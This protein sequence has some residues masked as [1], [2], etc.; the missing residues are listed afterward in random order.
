MSY[1]M[2]IVSIILFL[3]ITSIN[4]GWCQ[5][6]K[7]PANQFRIKI[8]YFSDGQLTV[9]RKGTPSSPWYPNYTKRHYDTQ[10]DI[11]GG[12]SLDVKAISRLYVGLSVDFAKIKYNED[13]NEPL[14][15]ISLNFKGK[16]YLGNSD[17]SVSPGFGI[18]YGILKNFLILDKSEYLTFIY[19]NEF[20]YA[21]SESFELV[22][23]LS[24]LWGIAGGDDYYDVTGGPF[25]IL[26][27]GLAFNPI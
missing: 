7:L 12:A 10:G 13:Y 17:F 1:R 5:G 25:L 23:D 27:G 26:R 6:T 8:G 14:L 19:R 20:S 2:A 18:G 24:L 22:Y 4:T 15:I 11:I 21:I 16:F 9:Q 3:I